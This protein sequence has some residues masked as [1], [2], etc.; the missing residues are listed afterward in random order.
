MAFVKDLAVFL[1]ANYWPAGS[2]PLAVSQG[3]S[4]AD[5][6][7]AN[8]KYG[9]QLDGFRISQANPASGR[10]RILSHVLTPSMVKGLYALYQD[11][12]IEA[13]VQEAATSRRS[14]GGTERSLNSAETAHMF[15]LYAGQARGLAGA[16]RAYFS[17][18]NSAELVAACLAA[19]EKAVAARVRLQEAM[20]DNPASRRTKAGS[21]YQRAVIRRD[22]ERANLAA[23]LRRS[24]NTRGL[25]ADSLVFAAI[26]LHRRPPE[27]APALQGLIAVMEDLAS[28]LEARSG[29]FQS[30]PT[31]RP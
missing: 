8:S 24:G 6:R 18:G 15:R 4:T 3:I 27:Q 7:R 20:A 25:D 22:Q 14:L 9:A 21:E 28:R 26:W 5:L 16:I 31:G 11:R 17:A 19:E 13:L 30:A 23:A 1:T 2:H 10:Q 29:S 12:F